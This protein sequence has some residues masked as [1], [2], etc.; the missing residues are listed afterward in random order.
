MFGHVGAKM[1]NKRSKM[2]TCWCQDG[3]HERQDGDQDRQDEPREAEKGPA[4]AATG[5]ECCG[6]G[7]GGPLIRI[8]KD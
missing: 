5:F 2:A 3:A 4:S 8:K 7:G 1:A 6:E